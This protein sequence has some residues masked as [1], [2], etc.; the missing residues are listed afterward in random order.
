MIQR[1]LNKTWTIPSLISESEPSGV[2]F[3]C[4]E[5]MQSFDG[6]LQKKGSSHGA[7]I[8]FF[9]FW[10]GGPFFRGGKTF[11]KSSLLTTL[12]RNTHFFLISLKVWDVQ[13]R[14]DKT[15]FLGVF[16]LA[17]PGA[18]TGRALIS[19]Y[20]HQQASP[21]ISFLKTDLQGIEKGTTLFTDL[22][23]VFTDLKMT[24]FYWPIPWK[25]VILFTSHKKYQYP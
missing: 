22:C 20:C 16:P 2:R 13:T 11:K 14:E 7:S 25:S 5:N 6:P 8:I 23:N 15:H 1:G 10:G 24:P 17:H 18:A 19:I 4:K 21:Q 3:V 12:Y 9:F